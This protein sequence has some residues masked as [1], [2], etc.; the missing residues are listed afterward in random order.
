LTRD[1]LVLGLEADLPVIYFTGSGQVLAELPT[2]ND[3]DDIDDS[4]FVVG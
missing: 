4:D 2:L 3:L 1:Q